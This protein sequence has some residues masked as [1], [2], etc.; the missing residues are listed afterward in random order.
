MFIPVHN[1]IALYEKMKE[2]ID[3]NYNIQEMA[4]LCQKEA[5]HYDVDNVITK[6]LLEE[7]GGL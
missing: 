2:C 1:V 6:E 3:G 5:S 4:K 7:I